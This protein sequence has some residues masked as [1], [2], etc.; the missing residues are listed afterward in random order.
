MWVHKIFINMYNITEITL[1]DT[2]I[3]DMKLMTVETSD[4]SIIML[5]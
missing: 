3:C 5:N 1:K 2:M 4:I